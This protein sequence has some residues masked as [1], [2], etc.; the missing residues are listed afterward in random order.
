M[1]DAADALAQVELDVSNALQEQLPDGEG[2]ALDADVYERWRDDPFTT[3]ER[4]Y[5]V[6]PWTW[7]GRNA[8]LLGLDGTGNEVVVN[9]LTVIFEDEDGAVLCQRYVDWLPA[10]QQAGVILFTRPIRSLSERV[11]EDALMAIPEYADAVREI[12]EAEERSKP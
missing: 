7:S 2:F 3:Q 12:R 8:G 6:V 9:G 5:L 11:D 10:L 1:I 4:T